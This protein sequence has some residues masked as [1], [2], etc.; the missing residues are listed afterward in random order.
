[1]GLPVCVRNGLH[2]SSIVASRHP[3]FYIWIEVLAISSNNLPVKQTKTGDCH[4]FWKDAWFRIS[5]LNLQKM[6]QAVGFGNPHPGTARS[7]RTTPDFGFCQAAM[8]QFW[9]RGNLSSAKSSFTTIISCQYGS[10]LRRN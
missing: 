3:N 9:C 7:R 4:I 5:M 1:M 6:R 8:L 10:K 2:S